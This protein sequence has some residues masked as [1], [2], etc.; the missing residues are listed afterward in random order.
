MM[1]TPAER[2]PALTHEYRLY[3]A[4]AGGRTWYPATE[5]EC[6]AVLTK[7]GLPDRVHHKYIRERVVEEAA[8]V[9]EEA[10]ETEPV[11]ME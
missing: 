10:E 11:E 3:Q 8:I 7:R 6:H 9:E 1:D 2:A 5:A 4:N